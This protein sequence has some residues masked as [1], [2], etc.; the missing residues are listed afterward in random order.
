MADWK[1]IVLS[2]PCIAGLWLVRLK[3]SSGHITQWMTAINNDGVSDYYK[4]SLFLVGFFFCVVGVCLLAFFFF[5][6]LTL[7]N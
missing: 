2:R 1:Q 6:L 3:H 7:L 4:F 5:L